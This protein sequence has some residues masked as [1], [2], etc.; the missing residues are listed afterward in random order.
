MVTDK[1]IDEFLSLF[2]DDLP[3]AQDALLRRRQQAEV[4]TSSVISNAT[5]ENQEVIISLHNLT[6]RYKVKKNQINA[7]NGINLDIFKGEIVAIVGPSGS[8]KS[9]LLQIL[10]GVDRP[11]EGSVIVAGEDISTLSDRKLSD[12]RRSTIGFIF[13]SFYLQPFLRLGDN[14]AVPAMFT[15]MKSSIMRE[16]IEKLLGL[17]HLEN[18]KNH[19]PEELSGGQIQ[20]AA[21]ARALMNQPKI[22]LADEPTGNLDS[23]NTTAIMGAFRA[24]RDMLG[25]TIVIVTHNPEV[26]RRADRII[27]LKDGYIV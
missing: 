21:I 27:Q 4:L 15:D 12:V 22:L 10:G 13:Q 2:N 1:Q 18:R 3:T 19:Y 25:T 14:I 23:E 6:K 16:R 24:V 8:G 20:R 17:V 5:P 26:A 11:T 7:L 9:T